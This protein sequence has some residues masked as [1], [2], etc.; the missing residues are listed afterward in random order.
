MITYS[1]NKWGFGKAMFQLNGSVIH[2]ACLWAIPCA[3]LAA[4]VWYYHK[5][6]VI[7]QVDYGKRKDS[8][9]AV[10]YGFTAVLG[11]LLIFRTQKAYGRY[12]E[13]AMFLQKARGEWFNAASNLTSFC[14][15]KP[16]KA[17]DVVKFRQMLIRLISLLF[18]N[19]VGEVA[20]VKNPKFEVIDVAMFDAS[21]LEF[22]R[23]QTDRSEIIMQWIQRLVIDNIRSGVIDVAPPIVSRVFQEFSLGIVNIAS[24]KKITIIPFP[25][26]Y[27][28]LMQALLCFQAV[29][30]PV[31][32]G[33]GYHQWWVASS[34][35]FII[36]L[37]SWSI[38][39]IAMEIEM[40]F[41]D[42]PNDLP[43]MELVQNMNES[44]VK[45]CHSKVQEM[46]HFDTQLACASGYRIV[47]FKLGADNPM[48]QAKMS[49]A[50]SE[51]GKTPPINGTPMSPI[52]HSESVGPAPVQ[53]SSAPPLLND[54][55]RA[56]NIINPYPPGTPTM[57]SPIQASVHPMALGADGDLVKKLEGSAWRIEE[58]LQRI[59]A[60]IKQVSFCA[61]KY[62]ERAER[63]EKGG[64]LGRPVIGAHDTSN[65]WFCSEKQAAELNSPEDR[66]I[67]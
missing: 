17:A 49:K 62:T 57:T 41:G 27:S 2:R 52:A 47:E 31:M 4:G 64:T 35:T 61:L 24:A 30:C 36:V 55:P 10:M 40:P 65:L 54:K 14:C 44:L 48:H 58:Q 45:L 3:A 34:Q 6:N 29:V 50:A 37:L 66:R 19:A 15:A 33:Y 18:C 51:G 13:C 42:D 5:H 56:P 28:Q 8:T 32:A 53:I 12:W 25:F 20:S 63:L 9:L 7:P 67:G 60:D 22:L 39:F 59:G 43:L 21:S 11:F 38:H 26:P 16:D 46:P 1:I 23:I